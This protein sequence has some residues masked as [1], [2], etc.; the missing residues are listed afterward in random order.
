MSSNAMLA[1]PAKRAGGFVDLKGPISKYL[2]SSF[3]RGA[4]DQAAAGLQQ[5]QMLRNKASEMAGGAD[6]LKEAFIG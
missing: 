6:E 2:Q 3:S 1:V 4:A 5:A